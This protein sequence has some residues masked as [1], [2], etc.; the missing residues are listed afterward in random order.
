MNPDY[1][2]VL[3]KRANHVHKLQDQHEK[4]VQVMA[5]VEGVLDMIDNW[6]S[7]CHWLPLE[8]IADEGEPSI[9]RCGA[10][11]HDGDTW[12]SMMCTGGNLNLVTCEDC[13][14]L[15]EYGVEL[16][17]ETSLGEDDGIVRLYDK[18]GNLEHT[19]YTVNEIRRQMDLDPIK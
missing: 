19:Y 11:V 15:P 3:S 2:K 9:A 10:V 18:D 5:D 16:L 8:E 4:A 13:R 6:D 12:R 7:R 17:S 14:D 1:L